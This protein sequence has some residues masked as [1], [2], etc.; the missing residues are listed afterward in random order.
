MV[1]G[2]LCLF[3]KTDTLFRAKGKCDITI[4]NSG[5]KLC[6]EHFPTKLKSLGPTAFGRIYL[7]LNKCCNDSRSFI[8]SS[9]V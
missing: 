9:Y 5:S 4:P 3:T 7:A 8:K 2:I 6:D 1:D